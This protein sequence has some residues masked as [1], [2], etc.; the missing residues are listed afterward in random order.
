[1]AAKMFVVFFRLNPRFVMNIEG[2]TAESVCEKVS[3]LMRIDTKFLEA[4]EK[5]SMKEE[6]K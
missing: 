1:M 2:E 5:H 6:N 4:V 3:S